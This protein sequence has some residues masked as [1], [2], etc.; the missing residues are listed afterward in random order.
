MARLAE[1]MAPGRAWLSHRRTAFAIGV[2]ALLAL[3][4]WLALTLRVNSDETQHLHV[5]WSWTQGLLPYRDLFDNHAPLF[6][7]LYAPLLAALGERADIVPWMRLAVIPWYALTLWLTY[8]LATVLFD[9]RIAWIALAITALQP[10]FFTRSVEFRP[11]DAWAAAW[12]ASLLVAVSGPPTPRRALQCGLLAGLAL[13]FSIKSAVLIASALLAAALVLAIQTWQRR[14]PGTG[15]T[16]RIATMTAIGGAVLPITIAVAFTLAGAGEAI[17][18]CLFVH[19][20]ADGLGRWS[21]HGWRLLAFPLLLPALAAAMCWSLRAG[22]HAYRASL[23]AWVF[24]VGLI[25][26]ALRVSYQPL[27]DKQDVLPLVPMLAPFAAALLVHLTTK[28]ARTR[29]TVAGFVLAELALTLLHGRPWRDEAR[30]YALELHTLLQL[31][32]PGDYVMD[33]KAESI[34]RARPSYWLLENVTLHRLAEGSIDDD[35]A[36]RLV[37]DRVGVGVFER[38]RGN[39]LDFVRR[40]YVAIAPHVDVAGKMLGAADTGAAIGFDVSVP[41]RY[42]IVSDSGNVAGTLDGEPYSAPLELGAG[43]H[44]F[45]PLQRGVWALESARAAALGYSPFGTG[46]KAAP[47]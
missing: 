23:R 11:D 17:R 42:A 20:V 36:A 44:E 39:D 1:A 29:A 45:I 14:Q 15:E 34:F 41:N 5:V 27:L 43:P 4:I 47:P 31:S 6:H 33:D 28:P 3:R 9:R 22:D 12:I 24:G 35:I 2:A 7:I 46:L 8:R 37:N 21:H 18:Y 25:Y 19:N 26:A 10:T 30:Q 32:S 13:A 16:L 38:E 40:N